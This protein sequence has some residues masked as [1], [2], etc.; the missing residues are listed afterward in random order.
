MPALDPPHYT[1]PP[2]NPRL[3]LLTTAE[4]AQAAGVSP[5]CIRQWTRRGY[6]KPVAR[7][8]NAN[9]YL[10]HHVLLVERDRRASHHRKPRAPTDGPSLDQE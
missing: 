6:L 9:L 4:A 5:A 1:D 10:E 2:G 3:R 7:Y 8:R